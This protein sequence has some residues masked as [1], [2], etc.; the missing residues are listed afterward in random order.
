M[1]G[2]RGGDLFVVDNSDAGWTGLRYLEEWCGLATSLD[3]AIGFFEARSLLDLDGKWQSLSKIRILMGAEVTLVTK[4]LLLEAQTSG[5]ALP[6]RELGVRKKTP[7]LFLTGLTQSLLL[8]SRV[9]LNAVYSTRP[10]STP[11]PTSHTRG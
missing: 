4:K 5:R 7:T 11:R 2:N 1:A 10:S 8:S 9:R 3:I 6:R